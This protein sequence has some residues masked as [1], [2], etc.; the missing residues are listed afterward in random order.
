MRGDQP[1]FR[2][3]SDG[4]LDP[5]FM[6]TNIYSP[7]ALLLQTDRKLLVGCNLDQLIRLNPDGSIDAQFPTVY[8]DFQA[9]TLQPD[10]QLLAA[11]GFCRAGLMP[12]YGL[13]RFNNEILPL[14]QAF[15]RDALGFR[16]G[17]TAPAGRSYRME[18]STNLSDWFPL[19]YAT[20]RTG[21]CEFLDPTAPALPHRFYRARRTD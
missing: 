15:P 1:L 2:L 18:T 5:S 13:A 21:T 8:D 16:V 12:V 6:A 19:G 3:N 11:G 20:N 17:V 4:S 9:M 7:R 14:L 10:G